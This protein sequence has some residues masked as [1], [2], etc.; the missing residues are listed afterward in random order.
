M[1]VFTYEQIRSLNIPISD[2]MTWIRESFAYKKKAMLPPKISIHP[3]GD[4]FFNTMPCLL[5]SPIN[6]FGVKIVSR[7]QGSVPSLDSLFLLFDSVTGKTLALMDADWITTMRTG[8]VTALTQQVLRRSGDN[9]YSFIGLGNTARATLLCMLESEPDRFFR[10]RLLKHKEQETSFIQRFEKYSN[11]SFECLDSSHDLI[12]GSDVVISCITKAEELICPDDSAFKEGCLVI[13]VHTR[14]FQN[15]DLFF[16]KVF[17]DDTNHIKGFR[18]F[19][20][21][22]SFSE[23]GDVLDGST[24]GRET[25]SERILCYNIGLGLHDLVFADKIYTLLCDI[26]KPVSLEKPDEKFWV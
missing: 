1:K 14:G 13:P 6:R 5:P 2:C 24:V 22:H 11:V 4:D 15:C 9:T 3:Q 10:V 21:F 20:L 16:D 19:N 7:I 18:Y 23:L 17:G 25:D 26:V 12:A 8:A